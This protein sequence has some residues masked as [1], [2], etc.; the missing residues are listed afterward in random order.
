[1]KWMFLAC[2]ACGHAVAPAIQADLAITHVTVIDAASGARA[3]QTVL[4]AGDRIVAVGADVAVPPRARVIDGKGK[5]LIP[6]LWDMHVHTGPPEIYGPMYLANGVVGVRD[7]GGEHDPW[8]GNLS[9]PI[10]QLRAYRDRVRAHHARG[11][12]MYLGGP[13]IDGDP[14]FWPNAV[15]LK[16]PADVP[17]ALDKVQARGVDFFK[18]YGDLPRDV[19]LA[20]AADAKKRGLAFAGHLPR[21]V[22]PETGSDAGQKSFEHEF[23]VWPACSS[24]RAELDPQRHDPDPK[25]RRAAMTGLFDS[26][27]EQ[28]CAPLFKK[29]IANQTWQDPTERPAR[30]AGAQDPRGHGQDGRCDVPGG[31]A[32][33]CRFRLRQPVRL[34][35]RGAPRGAR[36]PGRRRAHADRCAAR[37]DA[38]ARAVLRD[39]SD[40]RHDRGG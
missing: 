33:P 4:V 16:N 7:M 17:A 40:A 22:D 26:F 32:D 27:D 5:F 13:M 39:R 11:P 2:I 14:A 30:R 1:M 37:R 29:L 35:G 28:A 3:D 24:R 38:L 25:V 8:V 21:S 6:G 34:S 9:L 15:A 23:M 31:R 10:E 12:T 36:P 19:Y 18:V 20:L